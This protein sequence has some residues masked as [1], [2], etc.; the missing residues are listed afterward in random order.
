MIVTLN[1]AI[2]RRVRRRASR[3]H[4]LDISSGDHRPTPPTRA[5]STRHRT[6]CLHHNHHHHHANHFPQQQQQQQQQPGQVG[7]VGRP[8]DYNVTVLLLVVSTTFVVLNVPYCVSW[9]AQF[10]Y[11]VGLDPAT[12]SCAARRLAGTLLAA[13]YVA[14]VP[15]CLNYSVNFALYSVCARAFRDQLLHVVCRT[16]CCCRRRPDQHHNELHVVPR[17]HLGPPVTPRAPRLRHVVGQYELREFRR[18]ELDEQVRAS[19]QC[20]LQPDL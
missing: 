13:K 12:S 10:F 6:L 17:R 2:F 9:F 14:T 16:S 5:G 1:T 11:L 19:C 15:Y 3:R 18:Q 4:E 20:H 8:R 7:G